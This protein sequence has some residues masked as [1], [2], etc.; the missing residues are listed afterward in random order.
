[1]GV[2][3]VVRSAITTERV[4]VWFVGLLLV[5]GAGLVLFAGTPYRAPTGAVEATAAT[6][7]IDIEPAHGGYAITPTEPSPEVG[8]V[9]YPGARVDPDAYVRLLG[10]I[11]AE[12]SVAV[13]VP[14]PPLN[15]AFFEQ[16]LA[17]RVINANQGIEHW[18]VGGHSL[19]GAMACRYAADRPDR[20]D[21]LVLFGSYCDRSIADRDLPTLAVGGTADGVLGP[22]PA[23]LRPD[24][25][26]DSANVV[27]VDG[28]N[29][30]QFG[31]YAGQPGDEPASISREQAHDR[32]RALLATFLERVR[33]DLSIQQAH[34]LGEQIL[35]P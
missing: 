20:V 21:G 6:Q 32:L 26:P 16:G 23:A 29:H 28:L 4:L 9:F 11:A 34:L 5:A 3:G 19:G 27:V 13:F 31:S 25:L 22:P 8:L 17:D 24:R 30:T 14:R 1:M 2:T 7:D 15:L 35:Q 10:P 18:I 33:A 12:E